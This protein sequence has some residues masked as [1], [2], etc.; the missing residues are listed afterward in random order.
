MPPQRASVLCD[1]PRHNILREAA[2][3][4]PP[5]LLPES[6][7]DTIPAVA[8][9]VFSFLAGRAMG[10]GSQPVHLYVQSN[11]LL[12][13]RDIICW[14]GDEPVCIFSITQLSLFSGMSPR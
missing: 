3:P 8:P 12:V 10:V 6:V 14:V 11:C 4:Q 1:L 9:K 13:T 7:G 5:F 2:L